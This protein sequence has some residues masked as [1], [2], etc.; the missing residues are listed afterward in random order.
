MLE[1]RAERFITLIA[2]TFFV[3]F[4]QVTDFLSS[5]GGKKSEKQSWEK[6]IGTMASK[7]KG[8]GILVKKKTPTANAAPDPGSKIDD[9]K[10]EEDP[11]KPS[12]SSAA[13]KP[14]SLSLLAGDY[15]DSDSDLSLIHI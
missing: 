1:K 5:E 9:V 8:L 3:S 13:A 4:F 6:S 15:S 2:L 12:T 11:P 7:K 14:N 10:K